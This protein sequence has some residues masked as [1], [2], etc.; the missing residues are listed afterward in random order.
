MSFTDEHM[1]K[2]RLEDRID[3]EDGLH[4]WQQKEQYNFSLVFPTSLVETSDLYVFLFGTF[5]FMI[6]VFYVF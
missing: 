3:Y 2:P 5:T 1:K 4:F 6:I